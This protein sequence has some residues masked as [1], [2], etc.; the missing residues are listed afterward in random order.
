MKKPWQKVQAIADGDPGFAINRQIRSLAVNF[1]RPKM[2]F[3][4]GLYAVYDVNDYQRPDWGEHLVTS[5]EAPGKKTKVWEGV[6]RP[7]EQEIPILGFN[8]LGRPPGSTG[9]G[10]ELELE[11][12]RRRIGRIMP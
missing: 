10:E 6:V 12:L 5:V 8:F 4:N 1:G 11:E 7:W 3:I 9:F 2:I